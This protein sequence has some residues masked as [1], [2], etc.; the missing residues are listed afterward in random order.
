MRPYRFD[1]KARSLP[2][3]LTLGL[4]GTLAVALSVGMQN[5]GVLILGA[6]L[7]L[8]TVIRLSS[9]TESGMILNDEKLIWWHGQK[10]GSLSL[11]SIDHVVL[12]WLNFVF[13]LRVVLRSGRQIIIPNPAL[14]QAE[15]IEIQFHIR[16]VATKT[17]RR[18]Q[19]DWSVSG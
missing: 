19:G 6:L 9:A 5:I 2:A 10:K 4:G 16:G 1:H 12:Q 15:T 17:V 13:K 7:L 3:Y 14:P 18:V 8:P 11:S